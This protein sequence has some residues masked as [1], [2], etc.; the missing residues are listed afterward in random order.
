MFQTTE[1]TFKATNQAPAFG[2]SVSKAPA[3]QFGASSDNP[4][5]PKPSNPTP[6]QF[7]ATAPQV[8]KPAA[9]SLDKPRLLLPLCL[10]AISKTHKVQGSSLEHRPVPTCFQTHQ[11]LPNRL[12]PLVS[13]LG[14]HKRH[15][16]AT[17][18]CS[19]LVQRQANR[20][21]ELVRRSNVRLGKRIVG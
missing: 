8:E 6:F 9:S 12:A 14:R 2:S 20:R 19:A 3:F 15:N 4:T 10:V 11:S 1:T 21:V 7:G 13:N 16:K 18:P 5:N 17:T